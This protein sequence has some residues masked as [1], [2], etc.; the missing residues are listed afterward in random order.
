MKLVS[1]SCLLHLR[2]HCDDS[3]SA[4]EMR[5]QYCIMLPSQPPFVKQP[6]KRMA[7]FCEASL[8]IR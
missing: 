6:Q 7:S 8:A 1:A 5:T 4:R 3:L 2:L